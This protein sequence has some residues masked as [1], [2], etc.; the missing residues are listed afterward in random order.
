MHPAATVK[1]SKSG[2]PALRYIPA[3]GLVVGG[4]LA[5]QTAMERNR[6][7]VGIQ[8]VDP[9]GSWHWQAVLA[10]LVV[11]VVVA[12]AGFRAMARC[13]EKLA[14]SGAPRSQQLQWVA[15]PAAARQVVNAWV[16][17]RLEHLVSR[18][19]AID[20]FFFAPA[21]STGFALL[22]FAAARASLETSVWRSLGAR[23][24]WCA[25]IAGMLDVVE[26]GTM[27]FQLVSRRTGVA[28]VTAGISFVK[29]VLAF[30]SALF[31]ATWA[32]SSVLRPL[33]R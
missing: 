2:R 33:I 3:T 13:D 16:E 11:M 25:W 6:H 9:F 4:L 26:N 18:S 1:A 27:L 24:G 5:A 14:E 20:T 17:G 22:C 10:L 15:R 31:L 30:L 32:V 19:I 12:G 7:P 23:A 29:W 28:P 21:Y 8:L